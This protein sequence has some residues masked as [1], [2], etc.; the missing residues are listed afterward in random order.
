M[1]PPAS[2]VN[3]R[4]VSSTPRFGAKADPNTDPAS[5]TSPVNATGRRPNES[6]SGPIVSSDTAQPTAVTVA[7]CPATATV[8]SRSVAIS[9]SNGGTII[10]E[11]CVANT[12]TISTV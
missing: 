11:F 8:I 6:E 3:T 9:T 7:S 1:V 10:T 12:A 5:T 2:P 4:S